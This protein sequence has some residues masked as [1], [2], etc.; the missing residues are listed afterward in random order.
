MLDMKDF[1]SWNINKK[2]INNLDYSD[3]YF[4]E[5]DIFWCHMGI[6][7]GQEQ[8]GKGVNFLRPVLIFKKFNNKLSW[9]IPLSNQVRTGSF[10]FPLLCESNT[11]R[12]AIL[13]QLK[14]VDTKRL[15]EKIDSISLLELSF[16]KKK[17]TGFIQ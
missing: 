8:D 7:V 1:D 6:N 3:L 2:K 10:F 11:F 16:V 15:I 17:I 4:N 9:V 13:V 14:V 12:T 5:R